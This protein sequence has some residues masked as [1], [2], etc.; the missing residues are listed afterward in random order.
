MER[1]D[2]RAQALKLLTNGSA[3]VEGV[4]VNAEAGAGALNLAFSG[5]DTSSLSGAWE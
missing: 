4:C 2:E 5:A 1:E 3:S